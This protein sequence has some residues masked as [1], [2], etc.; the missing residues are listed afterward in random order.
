[1][2]MIARIRKIRFNNI[3]AAGD[4]DSLSRYKR[5]SKAAR[6]LLTKQWIA[7]DLSDT[8]LCSALRPID[9]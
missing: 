1:M 2:G 5:R 6:S 4:L 9:S 7:L 8:P 3:G